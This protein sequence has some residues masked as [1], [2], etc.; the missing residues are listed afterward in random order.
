MY[1][2]AAILTIKDADKITKKGKKD[3]AD[4][5]RKQAKALIKDGHLYHKK[6]IIRY[7]YSDKKGSK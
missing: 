6:I 4:W 3:I 7:L 5:L 1:K 2:S